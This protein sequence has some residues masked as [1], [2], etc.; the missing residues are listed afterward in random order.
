[1]S[2]RILHS[3]SNNH[4]FVI[5][6][7]NSFATVLNKWMTEFYKNKVLSLIRQHFFS[8]KQLEKLRISSI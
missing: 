2:V 3:F 1:M 8:E 7:E 5:L 6:F 4:L